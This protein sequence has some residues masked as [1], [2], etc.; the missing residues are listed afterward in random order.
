MPLLLFLLWV[1][2][3]GR[4]TLEVVLLGIVLSGLVIAFAHFA[5]GYRFRTELRYWRRAGLL[6][7]YIGILLYE[8]L[9]AN[10]QLVRMICSRNQKRDPVIVQFRAPLKTEFARV[11]LANSI[12]L[13]PGTV[14]VSLDGDLF[15]VHCLDA[16]MG[17]GLAD[18]KF[19]RMLLRVEQ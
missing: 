17:E 7:C 4:I 1:I 12:T 11:L 14:T 3:N 19:V 16:S 6:V 5:I 10:V 8:I 15:T 9:V 2:L 13:T 18:S